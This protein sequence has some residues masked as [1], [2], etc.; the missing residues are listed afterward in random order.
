MD[1][2]IEQQQQDVLKRKI[3]IKGMPAH[4]SKQDL[5][6]HFS[7]YGKVEKAFIM[8]NHKTGISRGFGFVEFKNE[9]SVHA[10]VKAKI[11]VASK[12]LLISLALE[13]H[14]GVS[15]PESN[16]KKK[17]SSNNKA[18]EQNEYEPP[19]NLKDSKIETKETGLVLSSLTFNQEESVKGENSDSLHTC[20]PGAQDKHS[21]VF[22]YPQIET[23]SSDKLSSDGSHSSQHVVKSFEPLKSVN[24]RLETSTPPKQRT[25]KTSTIFSC[26]KD[27]IKYIAKQKKGGNEPV[28]RFNTRTLG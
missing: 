5:I 22:L 18:D 12:E 26:F 3:Y 25:S 16:N 1:G 14:K 10:A 15:R 8:Y 4:Y 23:T 24:L 20:T 27:R 7:L 21:Q 13:R 11:E 2:E 17:A 19:T 6:D 28:Y 9:Q